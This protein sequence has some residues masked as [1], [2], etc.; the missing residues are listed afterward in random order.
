M[1]ATIWTKTVL[2][3]WKATA[4]GAGTM[5][6]M[7]LF[8]MSVYRDIDLAVYTSLPEVMRT[9]MNI[10]ADADVGSLAYGAIYASYGTLTLAGLAISLGSASIAGEERSGTMGLLLG[11]PK[12]RTTVIVSKALSMVVL[13]T[14]GALV[15]WGAGTVAPVWLNVDISGIQVGALIIHMAFIALFYGFVALAVGAWTGKNSIASGASAALLIVS[16]FAVGL[17]PLFENL[18]GWSRIFPWHYYQSSQPVLN[19]VNGPDLAVLS[20]GIAILAMIS[21]VG[22]NRRDLRSRS[23]G[24]TLVDRLRGNPVTKRVVDRLAGSARVSHIWTKTAS[25]HQGLLIV[26]A[27]LM[28]FMMGVMIGPLYG[29]LDQTLLSFAD[30]FPK[31]ILALVGGGDMTTPEGFYQVE[32]FGLM[33]PIAVMV[34]TLTIGARALA[35]EEAA[36]TMGLLLANPIKRSK[37]VVQKTWAMAIY[38]VAVGVATATGVAAGSLIGGLDMSI[39]N[40][41]ATSLLVTLLGLAFGAFALMLSAA[42]GRVKLAIYATIGLALAAHIVNSF[43]PLNESLAGYAKWSPFYYYLSSDPLL[44]GMHWGHAAVLAALTAGLVGLA[45]MFFNRRD[46]RQTG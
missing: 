23:T 33:A 29:L 9:L 46:L 43:L 38:A 13:T 42:T 1:L 37:I 39:S 20:A 25:E 27:A 44:T 2:D 17:L 21:I 22:V 26:T 35:G 28:F 19:G 30:Q 3:R 36:R 31:E 34:M 16:F 4:I 8:G 12:S 6:L 5:G 18:D 45:V 10:P 32:T 14:L 7:L 40:V 15:L 24:E 11:N 41:A